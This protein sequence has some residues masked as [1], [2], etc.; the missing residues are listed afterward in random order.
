M[1][2][3]TT[4]RTAARLLH[5]LPRERISRALGRLTEARV[6]R[7]VL[8][9]VLRAYTKAYRVDLSQ[10]IVPEGGFKTFN[11]FFTRQLRAGLRPIDATENALVSPADGRLDD[12][13]TLDES[14]EF[15]IKGNL[16]NARELLGDDQDAAAFKGGSFAIVY[17]SPRDYHRVHSPVSL[18][19]EHVRHI[20]GVLFPVNDFGVKHVPNLFSRNER[21]VVMGQSPEFGRVAV[22]FVGAMIVGRIDLAI[23][24]P[25]RPAIGG[26][27]AVERF[28]GDGRPT[29]AR[30]E[31]LGAFL[32][33][34][35]VVVF[36]ERPSSQLLVDEWKTEMLGTSVQMGQLILA[37]RTL[38]HG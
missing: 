26:P 11:Q 8:N 38:N 6:P 5:L 18:T 35:T 1:Q 34:S 3:K 28:T 9:G 25:S 22:V 21:V 2:T 10:A 31:E 37:R 19:V 15:A 20:P 7:T 17:L 33:G 16:Y 12:A 23:A 13:G 4:E 14:T 29:V 30:G 36:V 32:L 27:V 24:A